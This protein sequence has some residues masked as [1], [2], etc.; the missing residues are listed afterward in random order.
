MSHAASL[1]HVRAELDAVEARIAA[2]EE[3]FPE[4][5]GAP[6]SLVTEHRRLCQEAY[7]LRRD[8]EEYEYWR[9]M[10]EDAEVDMEYCPDCGQDYEHCR[11]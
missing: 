11:C 6:V 7:A 8:A 1:A 9:D 10:H 3:D 5:L 4:L 2:I